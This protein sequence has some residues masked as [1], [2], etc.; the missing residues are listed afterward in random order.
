M[1]KPEP[2]E[3]GTPK[4]QKKQERKVESPFEKARKASARMI[5]QQKKDKDQDCEKKE[6]LVSWLYGTLDRFADMYQQ[7]IER[8][9]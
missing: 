1:T 9:F 7:K 6:A 8:N 5:Q 3:G 4:K 2:S